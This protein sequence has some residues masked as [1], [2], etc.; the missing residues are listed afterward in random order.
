MGCTEGAGRLTAHR[1]CTHAEGRQ[2]HRDLHAHVSAHSPKYTNYLHMLTLRPGEGSRIQLVLPGAEGRPMS[3]G[4]SPTTS[5]HYPL[6]HP[7]KIGH[8]EQ[9]PTGPRSPHQ[10]GPGRGVSAPSVPSALGQ[11]RATPTPGPSWT[12]GPQRQSPGRL[13]SSQETD[14]E[15]LSNLPVVTQP[16]SGRGGM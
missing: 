7:W 9:G 15:R 3:P 10:P 13:D 14:S 12:P 1:T 11:H 6:T 16:L 5:P 4:R 2:T 8:S